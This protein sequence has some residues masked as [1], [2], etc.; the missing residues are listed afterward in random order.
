M[1]R[2]AVSLTLVF[3]LVLAPSIGATWSIVLVDTAT[4]EIAIGSATC[5]ES[6]N[7]KN[8]VPVIVVGRGGAAA[9]AAIDMGATN[10]KKI[11]NELK[12]GTP[13]ATILSIVKQGDIFKASRQYGIVDLTSAAAGFTGGAVGKYKAHRTG[14]V[15]TV[16]YAI[17]GNVL[18]GQPV[19]DAA[20]MAIMNSSGDLAD[21]LMAGMIAAR[22]MGG[23]GRCSCPT[24][25]TQSCGSPPPQ[26]LKSAH[27]GF[28]VVARMG[29][30]DGICTAAVGCASGDYWMDLNVSAQFWADADPVD[31]LRDMYKAFR[32]SMAGQPDGLR[33]Y[34]RMSNDSVPGDGVSQRQLH[35][36]LH[37]L[38]GNAI[39]TG[40]ATISVSHAE[41]SAGLSTVAGITDHG[42][43]TYT[44]DLQA[45]LGSGTD[46]LAV[47]I[48]G[49]LQAATIYP[50]PTLTHHAA[51]MTDAP[52]FSAS[53]GQSLSWDLL[54]P[55]RLAGQPYVLLLSI[56]GPATSRAGERGV[57]GLAPSAK[58]M[59]VGAVGVLDREA[60]A[61]AVVAPPA[62]ALL[63]LVGAELQAAWLSLRETDFRSNTVSVQIVP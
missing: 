14:T 17:Q 5:L 46:V 55:E 25:G 51:L 40:G 24:G 39:E 47:K 3:L 10:K 29:D 7:L 34:H 52:D 18:T 26:F 56:G 48:E 32:Q 2:R 11:F 15:G 53:A 43:G 42:N 54:G 50:Y 13:P 23:D 37:D 35:V 36:S 61:T 21:R 4:G 60:R 28:M 16:S 9:Q 30:V 38:H 57:P 20:E 41:S 49:G 63:P 19:I 31:Q 45:G 22:L 62:G 27:V 12:L 6:F 1:Y 44:I 59:L 58:R 33:S 8:F